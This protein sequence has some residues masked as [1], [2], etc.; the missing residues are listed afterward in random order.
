MAGQNG[1]ME[2]SV[3]YFQAILKD[4]DNPVN[5]HERK[6]A[7]KRK[8]MTAALAAMTVLV[9]HIPAFAH[10]QLIYT[11][12]SALQKGGPVDMKLIFTHPFEAGH[13]MD[14]GTPTVFG[15]IYKEDK[16]EDLLG[17]LKPI[18]FKSLS[19]AGKAFETTYRLKGMG[20]YLFYL[21]P[22]PYFEE[23]E[24]KYI[25]QHT[26]MIMNVAGLPTNWDTEVGLPAEIIPLDKPYGLWT[27]NTFRGVVK[28]KGK[29]VPFAEVEVEY[30]NHDIQG[31]AFAKK[32]KA[33]APQDAFVTQ[34]IK[35][36][37]N[38]VFTYAIPKAGWWG[39]ASLMEGDPIDGKDNEVG[40]VIWVQTRDMK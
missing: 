6:N 25:T 10:F 22:A 17:T 7:M 33:T 35:A 16:R 40:G 29:A 36:D 30:L 5:K 4:A 3:N 1:F 23:S 32:A 8:W 37:A 28:Y 11:P 39:F 20:D 26:K 9:L 14:M 15:V 13:T 24:S 31:N 38:G 18:E 2:K 34:T 27:G 21:S 19:N 12:D